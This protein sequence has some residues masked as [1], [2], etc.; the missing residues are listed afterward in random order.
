MES[1][2]RESGQVRSCSQPCCSLLYSASLSRRDE[3]SRTRVASTDI[4]HSVFLSA[5]LHVG[6]LTLETQPSF[7]CYSAFSP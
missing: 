4:D 3:L 1:S 5:V 6:Y 2:R 7:F